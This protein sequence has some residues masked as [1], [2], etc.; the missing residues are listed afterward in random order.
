MNLL[1]TYQN[2]RVVFFVDLEKSSGLG[3]LQR[4]L[5]FSLVFNNFEKTI[6][7]E[8][9][10]KINNFKLITL[11][12][13]FKKKNYYNFAVID[14][15]NINF[16]LEKKIK[17]RVSKVITIDDNHK[18][19]FCCDFL[20]NYDPIINKNIY[21]GKITKN[22]KLLIGK[23]Y[24]FLNSNYKIKNRNKK[25]LNIFIYFGQNNKIDYL[26]R[27]VLKYLNNKFIK[28]IFIASK[29]KFQYKNLNLKFK[30]FS[31]SKK[32]VKFMSDCDIIIISSGIIIYE[33]LSLRKLIY[34][35]PIS[36]NQINNHKY[37]VHNNY[38]KD[39]VYLRNFKINNLKDLIKIKKTNYKY[40]FKNFS[41]IELLKS[42]FF[43]IK[44]KK[45]L[46]ISIDFLKKED[47]NGIFNFQTKNYR[48]YFKN[49]NTFSF[50]HH[51]KYIDKFIKT[52]GNLFFTIKKNMKELIGYVKLKKKNQG[53]YIS[54]TIH[55]N[56]QNF[57]IATNVLKYFRS[58]KIIKEKIFAEIKSDN[59]RSIKAFK[60]AGFK[61]NKN[62][63]L[64]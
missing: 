11:E 52:D 20:L 47:V 15:Y 33:A 38:A 23:D 1:N 35:S 55:K 13:F 7:S 62:I 58:K 12:N 24:N 61:I 45:G 44:N 21:K 60:K 3:H 41:Q 26:K 19:R 64:I 30:D 16:S 57:N 36:T 5:K 54:I 59:L 2:R 40:F 49:T 9:K 4:I 48:K 17:S 63:K 50:I 10:I 14:N 25:Y 27:N 22:T 37:I 42:I 51:K 53:Y 43:G 39:L 34:T 31:S 56:Y 29:Y 46:N 18:R 6:V 32:V 8:K 28:N